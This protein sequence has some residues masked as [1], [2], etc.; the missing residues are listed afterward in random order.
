MGVSRRRLLQVGA[1]AA[2][3]RRQ[4]RLASTWL[5]ACATLNAR[6]LHAGLSRCPCEGEYAW[7]N[8][9]GAQRATPMDLASPQTEQ[10]LAD[11]I[12]TSPHR[13]RPRGS[14]HSFSGLVPSEGAILD[15]SY[16]ERSCRPMIQRL[17]LPRSG[18]ERPCFRPPSKLHELGPRVPEPAGHCRSDPGRDILHRHAWHRRDIDRPARLIFAVFGWSRHRARVVEVSAASQSGSVQR[19]A[20]SRL[21]RLG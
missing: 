13:I 12:R 8:W 19:P 21:A 20:K 15:V 11:Y 3:G 2:D 14:G 7:M 9:S 18:P 1:G 5:G 10:A 6:R 4:S 17:A 16:L